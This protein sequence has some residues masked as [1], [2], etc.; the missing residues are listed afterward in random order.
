MKRILT[1]GLL[2]LSATL[3]TACGSSNNGQSDEAIE[4]T[5]GWEVGTLEATNQD[6]ESFSTDDV[7]GKVWIA[8][9]IFT[10]CDTVCPPMTR[11][12]TKIQEG[13]KEENVDT[14]IVSFSVD[15]TVDTPEKLAEFGGKYGAD[16]SNWHFVTG[17][18]QETI[19]EFAKESFKTQADKIEGNDQV[20][21]GA[22]FYLVGEDGTV[23]Q[24]YNGSQDVP[25][26][27]IVED[28]KA[29]SE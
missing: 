27:Q 17:Y 23:L 22:S 28:A 10:S 12:M 6:G 9:F 1:I 19:A 16:T 7:E 29:A 21:H 8:D 14:E 4:N 13:L 18:D 24:K 3:L 5:L 15:P 11:N 20:I 26:E 25:Y 2:L